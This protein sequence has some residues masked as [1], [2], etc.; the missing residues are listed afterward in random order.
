MMV[1]VIILSLAAGLRACK[2]GQLSFWYD[3]IVTMRLA[4]A[5]TPAGFFDRLVQIDATPRR[6]IHSCFSDGSRCSAR[7]KPRAG[8]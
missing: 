4:T 6:C 5:P 3:E 7:P 1:L 8:L 2:L